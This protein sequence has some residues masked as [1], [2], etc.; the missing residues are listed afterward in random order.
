[1]HKE[2]SLNHPVAK[3]TLTMRSHIS[4]TQKHYNLKYASSLRF[5]PFLTCLSI[6]VKVKLS[7]WA[8]KANIFILQTKNNSILNSNST[9]SKTQTTMCKSHSVLVIQPSPLNSLHHVRVCSGCTITID[10]FKHTSLV[11]WTGLSNNKT[12]FKINYL[13]PEMY[14]NWAALWINTENSA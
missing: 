10:Y 5:E 2:V 7:N 3:T 11:T 9:I 12:I 8:E 14:I 6:L 1:M 13:L 4:H